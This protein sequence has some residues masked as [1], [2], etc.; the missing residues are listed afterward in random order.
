MERMLRAIRICQCASVHELSQRLIRPGVSR[1]T[2][3]WT[4]G[5]QQREPGKGGLNVL[6]F[7]EWRSVRVAAES[8]GAL[9]NVR[10]LPAPS[11]G[12]LHASRLAIPRKS[13]SCRRRDLYTGKNSSAVL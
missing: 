12:H 13:P 10:N 8:C 2:F 6:Y 9:L 11:P 3:A 1:E 5:L 4:C 7:T